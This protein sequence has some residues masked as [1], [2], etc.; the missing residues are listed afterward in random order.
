M[1]QLGISERHLKLTT[2]ELKGLERGTIKVQIF[3]S[4][5][6]HWIPGILKRFH[7]DYPGISV[8]FITEEDSTRQEEMVM[9]GE[10]DCG[11]FL[12][13]VHSDIDVFPLKEENLL[14]IV[15]PE[16]PLANLDCF[17]ISEIGKHPYISMKY[18]EHT[19][20]GDIFAKN[21][22]KPNTVFKIDNDYAAMAM[23]SKNLGFCIHAELVM[24]DVPFNV[25]KMPFDKPQKRIIS[26]GTS[27]VVSC[28]NAT[29][30]FIEYTRKW[31]KENT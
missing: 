12:T 17:P 2:D 9:S 18:D 14:A 13:K 26:I 15:S 7:D 19:V 6:V 25:K 30:K 28:S 21:R 23:V 22:I 27:S 20:I 8:E 29:L 4:I 16:H 31:V 5:S 24:K 1:K 3:D 10:V 11:F